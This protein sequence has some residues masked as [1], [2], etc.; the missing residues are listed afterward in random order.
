MK[1]EKIVK[2]QDG[3]LKISGLVTKP[4]GHVD[5]VKK[6]IYIYIIWRRVFYWELNHS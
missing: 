4:L 6:Y 5:T 1:D 2:N 3:G